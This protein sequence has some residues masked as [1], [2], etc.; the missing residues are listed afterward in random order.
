[1][2]IKVFDLGYCEDSELTRLIFVCH[3]K[4]KNLF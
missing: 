2:D 1:M 4:D 3:Y